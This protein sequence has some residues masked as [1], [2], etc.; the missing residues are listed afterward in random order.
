VGLKVYVPTILDQGEVVIV[1]RRL[2]LSVAGLER[3][4]FAG[5][6]VLVFVTSRTP[7]PEKLPGF[8]HSRDWRIRHRMLVWPWVFCW[9]GQQRRGEKVDEDTKHRASGVNG[10]V[11]RWRP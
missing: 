10:A 6:T 9:R 4:Y 5:H 8:G 11:E 3:L 1:E 7:N 2:D